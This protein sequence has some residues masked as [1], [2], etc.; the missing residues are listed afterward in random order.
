MMKSFDSHESIREVNLAYLMLVQ[1]MLIEDRALGLARL[2]MAPEIA[3]YL[4]DLSPSQM[5]RLASNEHLLCVFRFDDQ[6]MLAALSQRSN[7][8]S[9]LLTRADS[10]V[11]G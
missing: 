7:I 1:R 2:A 11:V 4:V 9:I 8:E 5:V 3:N 10:N 6:R